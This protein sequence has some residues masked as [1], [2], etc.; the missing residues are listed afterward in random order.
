MDEDV[1]LRKLVDRQGAHNWSH[2]AAKIPGRNSKQCR[3]RFH[4]HLDDGL[5]KGD[6][7]EAEDRLILST[8]VLYGNQWG[9][10]AKMLHGRTDNHVK[11]RY[12]FIQ[13][14]MK[15]QREDTS[16][17]SVCNDIHSKLLDTKPIDNQ[18]PSSSYV[19]EEYESPRKCRRCDT[20]SSPRS[21]ISDSSFEMSEMSSDTLTEY[22]IES[23]Y[24]SD[25]I[26][27][28]ILD[29]LASDM[30]YSKFAL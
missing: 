3:E 25:P 12:Y 11:N 15:L 21:E 29:F 28:E 14:N 10:I 22:S 2:I 30:D 9:Q 20:L 26:E 4:N 6:W 18:A 19:N 17:T 24:Y 13:R 23:D 5:R 1:I 16:A 27:Q 8:Q 7:S